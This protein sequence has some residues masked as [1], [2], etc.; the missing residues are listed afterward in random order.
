MPNLTD[1]QYNKVYSYVYDDNN[2]NIALSLLFR[3]SAD[4]TD[5]ENTVLQLSSEM[6]FS[7]TK[8]S[9]QQFVYNIFDTEPNPKTYK[10]L[11]LTHTRSDWRYSELFYMYRDTDYQFE[12]AAAKVRLPQVLYTTYISNHVGKLYKPDFNKAARFSHCAKLVG[13]VSIEF[14]D[15]KT[16][17]EFMSSLT[18]EHKLI[19]SRRSQFVATKAPSRFGS[20]KSSKGPAEVQLWKPQEGDEMRLA[21]R[22]GDDVEDKWLSLAIPR[23]CLENRK[24]SNR[25]TFPK[26]EYSRGRKIDMAN[27]MARDCSKGETEKKKFGPITIAFETFLGK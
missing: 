8:G 18:R 26:L 14:D 7:W 17:M 10:A 11:L 19:F 27:L 4:A 15:I 20:S 23:M 21:F 5:F 25:A 9:D 22:W 2:P 13:N 3:S 6:A 12:Y 24:D 1:G 16:C